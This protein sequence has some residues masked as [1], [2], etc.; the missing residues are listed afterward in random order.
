MSIYSASRKGLTFPNR[1]AT[2]QKPFCHKTSS[3]TTTRQKHAA[4]WSKPRQTHARRSVRTCT[5]SAR[6]SYKHTQ[7][8][9]VSL[10]D[11]SRPS[12][13]TVSSVE[14]RSVRMRPAG[15]TH[16]LKWSSRWLASWT[17]PRH[18]R[19]PRCTTARHPGPVLR[20]PTSR[21]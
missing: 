16:S 18:Y 21:L 12:T 13:L 10:A 7:N 15:T 1:L 3:K 14:W 2:I 8:A 5:S 11:P 4:R 20:H 9:C 6:T 19:W 17:L